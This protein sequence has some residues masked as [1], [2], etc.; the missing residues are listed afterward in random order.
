M[1]KKVLNAV[2]YALV[3]GIICGCAGVIFN[4]LIKYTAKLRGSIPFYWQLAVMLVLGLVIV[5]VNKWCK[6]SS[7]KATDGVVQAARDGSEFELKISPVAALGLVLTCL[8]ESAACKEG[9]SFQIGAPLKR[10][11]HILLPQ[12]R[13]YM[14]L[15]LFYCL[16]N[17]IQS[18]LTRADI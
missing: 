3:I 16:L 17:M 1:K 14:I 4:Y 12:L 2:I 7:F 5:S 13:C 10:S 8:A 9:G 11:Q 15:V 6:I 18:F